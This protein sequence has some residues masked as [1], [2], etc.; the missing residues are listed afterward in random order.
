MIDVK[1]LVLSREDID[2]EDE[3]R[4]ISSLVNNFSQTNVIKVKI[5]TI[6]M[7]K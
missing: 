4:K 1:S 6:L 3:P 5:T 7:G 2:K